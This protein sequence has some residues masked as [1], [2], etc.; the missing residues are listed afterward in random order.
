MSWRFSLCDCLRSMGPCLKFKDSDEF[1]RHSRIKVSQDGS[2]FL[3]LI[4][5]FIS[6]L[7]RANFYIQDLIK[8]I[9]IPKNIKFR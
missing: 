1:N 8:I 2:C 6:S 9:Y 4:K 5:M 7:V 3:K